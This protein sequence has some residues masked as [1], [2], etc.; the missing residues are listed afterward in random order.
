M[1]DR[2]PE[3]DEHIVAHRILPAMMILRQEFG[4]GIPEA[5]GAF[6]AR[7]RFLRETRPDDF[8]VSLEEYGRHFYS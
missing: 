6:D 5:I 7:Y 1:T 4:F 2:W 3:I 8:T